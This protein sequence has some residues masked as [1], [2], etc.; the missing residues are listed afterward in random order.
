VQ[1]I[2]LTETAQLADV[3]LPAASF[4]EQEGTFLNT[5]RRAQRGRRAIRPVGQ[6]KPDWEIIQEL[7]QKLNLPWKHESPKEIWD[8]V[9]QLTPHYFGGM[10]YERLEEVGLQWPCPTEEHPGT[11]IMHRRSWR[12]E[13]DRFARGMGQFSTVDYRPSAAKKP[14]DE[15]PFILTTARNLYQ[16]HTRSMTGRVQG[17]NELFGEEQ[18]EINPQDA[19]KLGISSGDTVKVASPRGSITVRVQ[20]TDRVP[21]GVVSMTFHFAESAANMITNPA[22]CSMS[23]ASEV[24][25]SP[26]N[27]EKIEKV[28]GG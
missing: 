20:I 25:I 21:A 13:E 3:I 10:S 19:E 23:V 27:I 26:V 18:M 14:D 8:E 24:K 5:E 12:G 7:A 4:A 22:V 28:G 11:P 16:Y 6:S 1:D 2:F 17:L 15:Y 9:R